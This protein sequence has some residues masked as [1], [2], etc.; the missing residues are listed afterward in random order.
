[1][2]RKV[3]AKDLKVL[4]KIYN[5]ANKKELFYKDL[6]LELFERKFFKSPNY[7][8]V[9]YLYDDGVIKGFI[10]GV[11][12]PQKAYITYIYVLPEFR[13]N[14]IGNLLYKAIMKDF[15]GLEVDLVFFNPAHLPWLIKGRFMHPNAPGVYVNSLAYDF[16]IKKGFIEFARQNVYFRNLSEFKYSDNILENFKRLEK[17]EEITFGFYNYNT[18]KELLELMENLKN[19]GWKKEVLNHVE[20]YK[21][22][23]TLIVARHKNKV[24]GFTGPIKN[25]NG[26]GYF[27]GIGVHSDYRSKGVGK[28]LFNKL[29]YELKQISDYMTLF[30]GVNNNARFIYESAGFEIA[31]VFGNL[32]RKV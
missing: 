5:N 29:C 8:I 20:T 26:R 23:N 32:R 14:Q 19:E 18:D 7:E 24:I 21:E 31:R 2:I 11:K 1:M 16:F 3:N 4:N 10:S 15:D 9:T 6:S 30:T 13:N 22:K 28:T 17:E 27:A 12:M 25:D